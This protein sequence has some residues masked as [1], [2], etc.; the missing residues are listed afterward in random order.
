M[1][2]PRGRR[3]ERRRNR[4]NPVLVEKKNA[5]ARARNYGA[6]CYGLRKRRVLFFGERKKCCQVVR[7]TSR[8]CLTRERERGKNDDS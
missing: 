8:R 3:E 5:I 4:K 2:I 7:P 6:E 1:D